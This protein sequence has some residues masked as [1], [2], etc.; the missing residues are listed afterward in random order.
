MVTTTLPPPTWS[1]ADPAA[2]REALA[3]AKA[4]QELP[5]PSFGEYLFDFFRKLEELGS[6]VA[7]RALPWADQPLVEQVVIYAALSAALLAALAVLWVA[8]RHWR[9]ERGRRA[10][11]EMVAGLLVADAP[12]LPDGDAAWWR[13]ELARR[14]AAGALRPA[15]EAAW[16]WTARRLDP[17]GLDPSWTTGDLV[18]RGGA[19]AGALRAPLRR[20]DRQL[21]GGGTTSR[22]DVEAVVA[23]LGGGAP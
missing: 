10:G 23:E 17:P 21:W 5:G 3:Q 22:G 9:A 7:G 18:R 14:L 13:A 1:A 4:A 11:G 15:L 16:W 6:S 19:R 12:A 2:L 8:V 20:L